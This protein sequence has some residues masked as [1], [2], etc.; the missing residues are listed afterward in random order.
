M[1]LKVPSNPNHH[2]IYDFIDKGKKTLVIIEEETLLWC[3]L[4]V[5]EEKSLSFPLNFCHGALAPVI[6]TGNG[7]ILS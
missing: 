4:Y 7:L 5:L 3:S 1:I 2:K 6:R